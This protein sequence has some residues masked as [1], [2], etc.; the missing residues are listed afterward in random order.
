MIS[1]AIP[2]YK[3]IYRIGGSNNMDEAATNKP[4]EKPKVKFLAI[5]RA[6]VFFLTEFQYIA[7]SNKRIIM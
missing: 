3:M 6:T 7:I 4:I 5:G 1:I 2:K